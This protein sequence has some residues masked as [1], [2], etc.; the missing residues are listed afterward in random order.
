MNNSGM[1]L[2]HESISTVEEEL[3]EEYLK[4]SPPAHGST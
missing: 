3:A 4:R 1:E 2:T